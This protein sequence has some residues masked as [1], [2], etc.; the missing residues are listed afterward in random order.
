MEGTTLEQLA[1]KVIFL[2]TIRKPR[3]KTL[4]SPY[5]SLVVNGTIIYYQ[6]KYGDAVWCSAH[7]YEGAKRVRRHIIRIRGGRS[8]YCVR[9]HGHWVCRTNWDKGVVG[10]W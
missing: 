7:K 6:T 9:N 3:W 2:S 4:Y 10:E 8:K 5:W 1:K